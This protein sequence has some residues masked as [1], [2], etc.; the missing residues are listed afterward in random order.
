MI[1]SSSFLFMLHMLY[2]TH[3]FRRD[4]NPVLG[5]WLPYSI[6]TSLLLG[7]ASSL[8]LLAK[9]TKRSTGV[10]IVIVWILAAAYSVIGFII[11][12]GQSG[13]MFA[14]FLPFISIVCGITGT[15]IIKTN[16]FLYERKCAEMAV[17]T[18]LCILFGSYLASTY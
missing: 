11:A 10:A 14:V 6:Q 8:H 17:I 13:A 5:D 9:N 18:A 15:L 3:S 4:T 7:I 2:A 12:S 16:S 1:A